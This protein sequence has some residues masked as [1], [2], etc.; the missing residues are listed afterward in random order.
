MEFCIVPNYTSNRRHVVS[1]H[2]PLA[3][4]LWCA[5]HLDKTGEEGSW[6]AKGRAV[7]VIL[8]IENKYNIKYEK[9]MIFT[10]DDKLFHDSTKICHICKNDCK[11]KVGDI[12]NKTSKNKGSTCG[13]SNLNLRLTLFQ[14]LMLIIVLILLLILMLIVTLIIIQILNS[15]SFK[16]Y[17]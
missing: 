2:M 1:E 9:S 3:V 13:I 6:G 5:N 8:A 15:H 7:K 12:C 11:T 10:D 16:S 14:I 4:V 17:D